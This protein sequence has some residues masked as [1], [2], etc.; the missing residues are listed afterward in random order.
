MQQVPAKQ[1]GTGLACRRGAASAGLGGTAQ[2]QWP[3]LGG[4][5]GG[6]WAPWYRRGVAVTSHTCS[7]VFQRDEAVRRPITS[8]EPC[9]TVHA[10]LQHGHATWRT[11]AN[12]ALDLPAA[13][14]ILCA[15]GSACMLARSVLPKQAGW[16]PHDAALCVVPSRDLN[17]VLSRSKQPC[18]WDAFFRLTLGRL[19]MA[20]ASARLACGACFAAS[21]SI[22]HQGV[23]CSQGCFNRQLR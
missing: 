14:S 5:G 18:R 19:K 7:G 17:R 13:I 10:A 8:V 1:V 23:P 6:L 16:T 21:P 4:S 12:H 3:E 9:S 22:N 20:G 15:S 2:R 11:P